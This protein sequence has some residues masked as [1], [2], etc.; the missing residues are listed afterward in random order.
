MAEHT[1]ECIFM[2]ESGLRYHSAGE[3]LRTG[4]ASLWDRTLLMPG[5]TGLWSMHQYMAM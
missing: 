3:T 5:A 2:W 1:S 4:R